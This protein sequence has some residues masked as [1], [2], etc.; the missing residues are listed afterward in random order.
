MTTASPP[1]AKR[2]MRWSGTY[3]AAARAGKLRRRQGVNALMAGLV[4][5]AA[6]LATLPLV[7]VLFYLLTLALMLAIVPCQSCCRL[8]LPVLGKP[9]PSR[10]PSGSLM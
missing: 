3:P 6:V 10:F 9:L 5:L 1:P 7:I 2:P 8:S 4:G